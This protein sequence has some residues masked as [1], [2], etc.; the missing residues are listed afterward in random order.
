MHAL[1]L[2]IPRV[3]MWHVRTLKCPVV[4]A[5]QLRVHDTL[6]ARGTHLQSSLQYL[7]ATMKHYNSHNSSTNPSN[8]ARIKSL[9]NLT[10]LDV[11]SNASM[12]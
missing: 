11:I 9:C 12:V 10:R 3:V 7:S 5:N 1:Q 8:V 6:V 2:E 4:A